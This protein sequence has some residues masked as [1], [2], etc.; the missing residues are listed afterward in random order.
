MPCHRSAAGRPPVPASPR[1]PRLREGRPVRRLRAHRDARSRP[2]PR[3][4]VLPTP[5]FD[6]SLN[7]KGVFSA[8]VSFSSIDTIADD[9]LIRLM[10]STK[11][12]KVSVDTELIRYAISSLQT[13]IEA[14]FSRKLERFSGKGKKSAVYL[15]VQLY[16]TGSGTASLTTTKKVRAHKIRSKRKGIPAA[17]WIRHAKQVFNR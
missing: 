7:R 15:G 2:G 16:C 3:A 14:T 10:A 6:A 1:W 12:V 11:K 8:R 13:E 4:V 9:C 5:G 17:K